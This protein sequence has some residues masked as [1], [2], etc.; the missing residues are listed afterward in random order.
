M[1]EK[2]KPRVHSAELKTRVVLELIRGDLSLS[3]ASTRYGI[4]ESLLSR[5]K[6][7]FLERAPTVFGAEA[8]T[9]EQERRLNDLESLFKEQSLELAILKKALSVSSKPKGSES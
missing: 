6:K 4:K 9:N 8:P 1:F 2:K 3:V 5:W 7:E